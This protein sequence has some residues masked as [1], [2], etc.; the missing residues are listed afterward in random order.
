MNCASKYSMSKAFN[1]IIIKLIFIFNNFTIFSV[2]LDPEEDDTDPNLFVALL[3]FLDNDLTSM[4]RD[5][6]LQNT[7]PS[8]TRHALTLKE[9]KPKGG[10]HFSLQQQGIQNVVYFEFTF[11]SKLNFLFVRCRIVY[12]K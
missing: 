2:S 7:L 6:F 5:N 3:N 8:L 10:L 1:Q 12:Q 4:E 11:K 9:F